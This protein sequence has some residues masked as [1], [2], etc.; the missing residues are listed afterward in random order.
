VGPDQWN[1]SVSLSYNNPSGEAYSES[2]TITLSVLGWSGVAA[3]PTPT[4]TPTGTAAPRAQLSG[5][6]NMTN[7][8]KLQPGS[9]F[10]LDLEVRNLGGGEARSITMILGGGSYGSSR[11]SKARKHQAGYPAAAQI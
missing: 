7:I 6:L 9:I 10:K 4:I 3:T 5:R 1:H 8:E 2:F 11:T